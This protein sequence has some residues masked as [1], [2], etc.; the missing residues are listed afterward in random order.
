MSI[1]NKI[2][3]L[4]FNIGKDIKIHKIDSNNTIIEINYDEYSQKFL[5]LFEEYKN[6]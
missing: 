4:L 1:K 2:D 5:D 6:G 3:E